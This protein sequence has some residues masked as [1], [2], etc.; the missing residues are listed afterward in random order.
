MALLRGAVAAVAGKERGV[1]ALRLAAVL[2]GDL[3]GED[4]ARQT[5]LSAL[6]LATAVVKGSKAVA[7]SLPGAEVAVAVM[8]QPLATASF[9][10]SKA[11]AGG[12][13]G[14]EKGKGKGKEGGAKALREASG[15]LEAALDGVREG[16]RASGPLRLHAAPAVPIKQYNPKFEEAFAPEQDTDLDRERAEKRKLKRQHSKELKGAVRELRKDG[17]FLAGEQAD[18]LKKQRKLRD[19]RGKA[20]ETFLS[21][22]Q[23]EAKLGGGKKKKKK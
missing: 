12:G 18:M 23:F 17:A 8:L 11:L 22:Q 16:A 15:E 3:E 14:K 10:L 21:K 19:E 1:E 2:S 6:Q 20:I 7:D 9:L 4:A 5:L 13:G